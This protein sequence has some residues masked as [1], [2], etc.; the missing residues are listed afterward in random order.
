MYRLCGSSC[1]WPDDVWLHIAGT[2]EP[3]STLQAKQGA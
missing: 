1:T 2:N 3:K